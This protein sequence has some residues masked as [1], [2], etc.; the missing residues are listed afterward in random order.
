MVLFNLEEGI[1]ARNQAFVMLVTLLFVSLMIVPPADARRIRTRDAVGIGIGS[2]IL[3]AG[4]ATLFQRHFPEEYTPPARVYHSYPPE[5][6][7][8][9]PDLGQ[10]YRQG[11]A[12]GFRE[13]QWQ[14]IRNESW[15]GY[16]PGG[17]GQ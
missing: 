14:R 3:G 1:M 8:G 7:G 9:Y 17:F 6:R 13:G 11:Y 16:I 5:Y 4:V 12:D 15:G 2:F 10:A